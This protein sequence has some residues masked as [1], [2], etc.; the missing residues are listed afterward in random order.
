MQAEEIF[1]KD[2]KKVNPEAFRVDA[3]GTNHGRRLTLDELAGIGVTPLTIYQKPDDF[4][5]DL[6]YRTEQD[7]APYIVYIRKSDEQLAQAKQAKVNAV[8][9]AYLASTDWYVTRAM[10]TQVVMPEDILRAR[11]AARDAIVN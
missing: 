4:S 6:Y 1:I 9:L 5:D 7:A 10:E 3:D 8:N 11:Q 2:G